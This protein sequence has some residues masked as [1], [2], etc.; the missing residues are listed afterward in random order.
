MHSPPNMWL[1]ESSLLLP[2]GQQG[3]Q[4]KQQKWKYFS[5]KRNLLDASTILISVAA[6]G[7][8]VKRRVLAE[9]ILKQHRQDRKK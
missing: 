9:G 7:L 1:P 8:Y 4:L 3:Q 5:S 6:I 2:W